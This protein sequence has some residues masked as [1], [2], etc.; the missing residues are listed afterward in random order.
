MS[1]Y[2]AARNA[3][4]HKIH[5]E[6]KEKYG[7]HSSYASQGKAAREYADSKNSSSN[8]QTSAST[9]VKQTL[10]AEAV[11]VGNSRIKYKGATYD[12][13]TF[14]AMQARGQNLG[15]YDAPDKE[16]RQYK[17][18]IS[19]IIQDEHGSYD[20]QTGKIT[21]FAPKGSSRYGYLSGIIK[22]TPGKWDAVE[23]DGGFIIQE[24]GFTELRLSPS[25]IKVNKGTVS[26]KPG[27]MDLTPL[28]PVISTPL[29]SNS[30]SEG[31]SGSI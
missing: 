25:Q 17:S 2:I 13:S 23:S 4:N 1:A 11:E 28:G 14:Y 22:D 21:L 18:K 19:G 16:E 7:G 24:G 29:P 31:S 20:E 26:N 27:H 3:E 30:A 5:A 12:K 8:N 10:P 15:I 6:Y 9:P